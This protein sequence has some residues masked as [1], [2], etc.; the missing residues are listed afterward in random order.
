MSIGF[1]KEARVRT[2]MAIGSLLNNPVFRREGLP[3]GGRDLIEALV[4]MHMNA[5][6]MLTRAG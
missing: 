5:T 3:E 4:I 2:R 1:N 6:E